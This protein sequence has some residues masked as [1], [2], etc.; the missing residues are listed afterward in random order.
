[1][2][3][4]ILAVLALSDCQEVLAAL[5]ADK[6]AEAVLLYV[7]TMAFLMSPFMSGSFIFPA[8]D[9]QCRKDKRGNVLLTQVP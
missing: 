7:F 2:A 9:C 6:I 4:Y 3:R 8:W 5:D 1:M